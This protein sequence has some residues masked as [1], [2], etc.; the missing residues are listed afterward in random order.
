MANHTLP[1][2]DDGLYHIYNRAVGNEK[3]FRNKRYYR[4]FMTRLETHLSPLVD[5]WSYCLLPNHFHLLVEIKPESTGAAISKGISDC[6]NSYTKW[7][8]ILNGRKG[9][10]FM[11]PFKRDK[12]K[13]GRHLATIIAYIHR[14]PIHHNYVSDLNAWEFCSYKKILAGEPGTAFEKVIEFLGG[15]D[16]YVEFHN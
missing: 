8:N 12:I 4:Q 9:S 13:D 6:C 3:L 11:R 2:N 15:K 10:L 14:N 5:I 1:L 7:L 16:A